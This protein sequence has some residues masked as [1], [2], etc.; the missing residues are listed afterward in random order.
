MK[1]GFILIEFVTAIAIIAILAAILFP[2]FARA[3]EK[4]RQMS[5]LQNLLNVG[6]S[7]R[8]Y[9]ADYHGH[10]PPTDNDLSPLLYQYLPDERALDCPSIAQD[11]DGKAGDYSYKGGYQEDDRGDL[12]LMTDRG[13]EPHNGGSNCLFIDGHAKW[14][15]AGSR[16]ESPYLKLMPGLQKSEAPEAS[17]PP[18]G[19]GTCCP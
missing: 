3:R 15:K 14:M 17:E 9:A 11:F 8:H 4:A 1:R 13:F 6:I 2:V 12:M 7:L 19:G 10:F 18:P 5:C 16:Y